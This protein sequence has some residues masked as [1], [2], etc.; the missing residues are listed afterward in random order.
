MPVGQDDVISVT[1]YTRPDCHLCDD[2]KGVV[3]SVAASSPAPIQIDIVDIAADPALE[4]RY[5]LEIPVLMVNG[6]KAAK[7]RVTADELRRILAARSG[8]L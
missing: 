8:G 5:A 7:Y 1:I 2:M 3:A 6:V 4:A